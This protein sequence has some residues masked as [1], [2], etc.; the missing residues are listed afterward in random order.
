MPSDKGR[1]EN[2]LHFRFCDVSKEPLSVLC[3]FVF[4]HLMWAVTSCAGRGLEME[5]VTHC[6]A[7]DKAGIQI[8]ILKVSWVLCVFFFQ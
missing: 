1:T 7:T 2:L 3:V 4:C 6:T 5:G 8:G